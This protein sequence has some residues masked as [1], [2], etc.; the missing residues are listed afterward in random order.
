MSYINGALPCPPAVDLEW[1][2]W[3]HQDGLI[4]HAIMAFV[5]LT[6]ACLAT[7]TPI[8]YADWTKLAQQ[9]ANKSQSQI[10]GLQDSLACLTKG[11]KSIA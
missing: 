1:K 8:A 2:T 11:I 3:V 9:Y 5:D 10:Y 4:R 6:I 7:M